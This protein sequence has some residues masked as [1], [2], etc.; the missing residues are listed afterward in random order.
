[1]N[2]WILCIIGVVFLGVMLEIVVPD[3]KTNAFI[4]SIF[5]V[6]FMVIV[7]SPIIKLVKDS[8]FI[9]FS[10]MVTWTVNQDD[11][12]EQLLLELK[13]QIENHLT[14]NG[15]EGVQVEV[16]GY[17]TNKDVKIEQI[18]VDLSNLVILE[19]DEHINK[20]KLITTLIKEKVEIDEES[21]IYG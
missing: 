18:K 12:T 14:T 3:G 9:D 13:F 1:M 15:V 4:R 10:D 8:E 11:Y 2:P 5:A 6:I 19:K 17:S 21:I 7:V 20:Y 16:K